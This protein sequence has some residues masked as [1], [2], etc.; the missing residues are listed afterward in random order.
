MSEKCEAYNMT[1][2]SVSFGLAV[3]VDPKELEGLPSHRRRR[4]LKSNIIQIVIPYGGSADLVKE[5][6]LSVDKI[7]ASAELTKLVSRNAV[8]I[9]IGEEADPPKPV[10]APKPKTKK[11]EVPVEKAPEE[12]PKPRKLKKSKPKKKG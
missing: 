11:L 5:T 6:G 9:E 1:K 2:G 7:V 4:V 12:V 8:R 10:E 3:A